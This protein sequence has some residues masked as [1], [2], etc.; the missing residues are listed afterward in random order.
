MRS[1][2]LPVNLYEDWTISTVCCI[3]AP[4]MDRRSALWLAILSAVP[5]FVLGF[6]TPSPQTLIAHF[7]A[8]QLPGRVLLLQKDTIANSRTP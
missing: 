6:L 4:H 1:S 2:V 7:P 8:L 5:H 3:L